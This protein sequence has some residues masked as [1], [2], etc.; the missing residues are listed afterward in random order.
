M[1][2]KEHKLQT[3]RFFVEATD[4]EKF[5][6]W[7]EN[8]YQTDPEL[9]FDWEEDNAGF[10]QCVGKI[11]DDDMPVWVSFMFAKINNVRVCFY[12]ATS[13][14]VDHQMV[15]KFIEEN[16]PVKYDKGSRIAMTNA[17]NF[18]HAVNATEKNEFV[19][20]NPTT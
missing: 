7:K 19:V 11:N 9:K 1:D 20:G 17:T 16:Y 5:Y 2:D 8:K 3:T 15:E 14:F 4:E 13:R 12:N 10:M 18:H 6:L